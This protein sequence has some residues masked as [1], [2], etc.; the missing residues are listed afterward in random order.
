M[1][2]RLNLILKRDFRMVVISD[3]HCG[4]FSGL[5]PPDFQGKFIVDDIAKHNKLIG[6]QKG[7][8]DFFTTEIDQLKRERDIDICVCNGDAIDGSGWRS[9]GTELITT[10]RNKQVAMAKAAIEY[11]GAED[12][13]IVAGTAYHTGDVE[14]FEETL[15]EQVKG[16]FENH[17][18]LNINNK[19][20]D[21]RHHIGS[22]SVPHGRFSPI[23]KEAVW[24]KLW[25]ESDLI[26][27]PVHFLIRSHVHYYTYVE[28][29]KMCAMTT[30]A[31]QGFGSKFGSRRCNGI[32]TVGFLSFD[33]KTNGNVIMRKHFADLTLQKAKAT[34]Y[35]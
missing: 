34:I 19:V 25:S 32:P 7:M 28:D 8:W 2:R 35:S 4:H 11:I 17:A 16:K 9:G 14:D 13:K 15:A 10:D 18:Y 26:P 12:N 33:I 23:A 3:L 6:I 27:K 22:S 5:T 1:S 24:A 21:I 29:H 31:L 30:P 20:F